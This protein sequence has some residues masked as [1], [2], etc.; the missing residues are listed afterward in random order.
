[1][2][3]ANNNPEVTGDQKIQVL[4]DKGCLPLNCIGKFYGDLTAVQKGA[5]DENYDKLVSG[6]PVVVS[7]P[8]E[9][10]QPEEVVEET[11]FEQTPGGDA[12]ADVETGSIDG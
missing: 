5:V 9:E 1:M 8:I 2:G 6:A 10:L 12:V 11:Q 7:K 3:E 4:K